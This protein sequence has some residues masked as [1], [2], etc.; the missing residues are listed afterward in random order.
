MTKEEVTIRELISCEIIEQH[1][2]VNN[3]KHNET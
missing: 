3:S 1:Q 2:R